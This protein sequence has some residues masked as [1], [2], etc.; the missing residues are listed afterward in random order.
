MHAD[1]SSPLPRWNLIA[2][3]ALLI[4]HA[5]LAWQAR[6]FGIT[7]G[8]DDATFILLSRSLREFGYNDIHLVGAPLH[9]RTPPGFPAML[10]FLALPFGERFDVFLAGVLATSVASLALLYDTVRRT[11]GPN[12]GLVALALAAANPSIV[13]YAG[14]IM[15]EAPYVLLT[16]LTAWALVRER[17]DRGF[18]ARQRWWVALAIGAACAASLTRT[19]GATMV[20][21]LF[22]A[23]VLERRYRPLIA[24]GLAGAVTVGGWILWTV[25][26]PVKIVGRSY[27]ADAAFVRGDGHSTISLLVERLRNIPGY[28]A[29]DVP[30]MLPLPTIEG[31]FVDNAVGL[32]FVLV[33]ASAGAVA[34]W[35]RGTGR[36]ALL[37]LLVYAGLLAVWPWRIPRFVVPLLPFIFWTLAAGAFMLAGRRRWMRPLPIVL[38]L[39]VAGAALPRTMALVRA[40]RACDRDAAAT[41]ATCY[42]PAQRSFFA[43]AAYA[44]S[45]TPDTAVFVTEKEGTFGYLSRRR[46]MLHGNFGRDEKEGAVL[47]GRLRDASADYLIVTPLV[48]D[49]VQNLVALSDMC[50]RL[51][52]ARAFGAATYLLRI[53]SPAEPPPRANA[54]DVLRRWDTERRGFDQLLLSQ[55]IRH[56]T[57]GINA[58]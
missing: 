39:I 7:T 43:L 45:S 1:E 9:P 31:T 6:A 22:L 51:A 26:A 50:D 49:Y 19:I 55:R 25:L 33:L 16:M 42:A 28:I 14:E 47:L 11:S 3:V 5:I 52:V 40:A 37:Y 4:L 8:N 12:A 53:V 34:L 57:V 2:A 21:A 35:K 18:P 58:S 46:V 48:V 36:I 17:H 29:E 30:F 20:L 15:S 54:C 13:N 24:L 10:A 56:H 38:V 41:S 23:W 32:L 44:R 27:V